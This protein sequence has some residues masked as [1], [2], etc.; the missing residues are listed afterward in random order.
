[1]KRITIIFYVLITLIRFGCKDNSVELL[2]PVEYKPLIPLSVGNYWLYQG[3]TLNSDSSSGG[4]ADPWKF[5]FIIQSPTAKLFKENNIIY[6]MSRCGED[7][8]PFDDTGFTLY[9]GNKLVYQNG[10]GLYYSGVV[11]KDTVIIT[12]NDLI[13][14]YPTEKNKSVAGHVFYYNNSG[15]TSNVSDETITQYTCI[16]LDSLFS[17]PLG[18]F[19]CIVY[20]MAWQDFPPL[21]RDEVY[22]FVKPGLGIV[23]MVQMVYH[24]NSN[25]YTY[26]MKHVLTDYR[27]N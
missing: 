19:R 6:Q 22:Y 3:Y 24:Y 14:P 5:G 20:K 10:K 13:F 8:K 23:G 12:F 7:L 4:T 21:F 9:G 15:N 16:S 11:R 25:K 2:P 1:M 26:F 18:D 27:I 17:T